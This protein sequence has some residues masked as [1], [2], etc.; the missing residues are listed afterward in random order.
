MAQKCSHWVCPGESLSWGP[1]CSTS[2]FAASLHLAG[3]RPCIRAKAAEK[4][5]S[6]AVEEGGD[7]SVSEIAVLLGYPSPS[8]F[9]HAFSDFTG[10][11]PRAWMIQKGIQTGRTPFESLTRAASP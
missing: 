2:A 11:S 10:M 5:L 6:T 9:C 7:R 1:T 8:A 3:E 4:L